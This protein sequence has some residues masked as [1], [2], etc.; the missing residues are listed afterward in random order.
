MILPVYKPLKQEL[1]SETSAHYPPTYGKSSCVLTYNNLQH[2]SIQVSLG[3]N[4]KVKLDEIYFSYEFINGQPYQTYTDKKGFGFYISQLNFAI[5]CAKAACGI[6]SEYVLAK[7]D[8]IRSIY[9]FHVVFQTWKILNT[10]EVWLTYVDEFDPFKSWYNLKSY[11]KLCNGF[12][13][14]LLTD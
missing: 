6:S 2:L 13:V 3:N 1:V 14:H 11:R 12:D 10:L 8:M 7:D 5:H 9:H 4:F